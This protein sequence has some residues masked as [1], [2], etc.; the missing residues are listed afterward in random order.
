MQS[1]QQ[2]LAPKMGEVTDAVV[3]AITDESLPPDKRATIALKAI[4]AASPKRTVSVT[5]SMPRSV[6]EVEE[7]FGD[8][9]RP[10]S[11]EELKALAREV[12]PA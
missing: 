7:R 1:R 11:W 5:A 12:G 9:H 3:G 8:M 2:A 10:G 6:E 4:N